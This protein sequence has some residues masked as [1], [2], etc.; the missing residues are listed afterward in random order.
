MHREMQLPTFIQAKL[1]AEASRLRRS[2]G[3]NRRDRSS[4]K[5]A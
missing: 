5:S 3:A 2:R 4:A 1:H